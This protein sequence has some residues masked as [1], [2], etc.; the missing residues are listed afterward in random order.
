MTNIHKISIKTQAYNIR[1]L[2]L[3]IL[4]GL[5]GTELVKIMVYRHQITGSY[6]SIQNLDKSISPLNQC[7]KCTAKFLYTNYHN[8]LDVK[9]QNKIKSGW[10]VYI[11][12]NHKK[13]FLLELYWNVLIIH[14]TSKFH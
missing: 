7:I 2:N 12:S 9:K 4:L 13:I 3:A 10:N 8:I 14:I 5:I 6:R 11:L 1:D